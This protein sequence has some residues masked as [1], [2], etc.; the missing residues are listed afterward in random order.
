[1]IQE[2][3]HAAAA[4]LALPPQQLVGKPLVGFV[5]RGDRKTFHT[6]LTRLPTLQ[7]VQDW[8]VCLQPYR[9]TPFPAAITAAIHHDPAGASTGVYWL[10]HDITVQKRAIAQAQHAERALRR[11]QEQLRRLATHLQNTQEQERTRIAREIHDDLAQTLTGL[12]M[13]LAWFAKR[14]HTAPLAWHERLTAMA[15][16]LTTM[17]QTVRRIGTEL[18]PLMLDELGLLAAIPWYLQEVCQ[19]AS[20]AYELHMPTEELILDQERTTALFRIFQ[21][22]LTN[23]VRHAEAS[24]VSVCMVQYP[25]AVCLEVADDG[26]GCPA[27]RVAEPASLGILGMRERAALW[28]GE[29][30]IAERPGGGTALTVRLPLR[31]TPG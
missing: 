7:R 22:A 3:N 6:Q 30:T 18:R 21:E 9:G 15:T 2:A 17:F 25:D 19:R 24:Q 26:K 1:M 5:A 23:V 10:V 8:E 12:K 29:L 27:E 11:S 16:T 28:G 13:D 14:L 4:L 31:P 20:L